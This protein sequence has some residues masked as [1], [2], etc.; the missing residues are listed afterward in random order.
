MR[1]DSSGNVLVG[2]TSA[3]PTSSGVNTPGQELSATGGV[4]STVDSNPAATFNRKTDD[5]SIVLFRKNGTTVGSI[6]IES[7]GFYVDG[8]AGHTG[9]KFRGFDIIPRDNGSDVDAGVNLGGTASRFAALYLS[10]GVYLGGTGAANYLD[11]YEEGTWIPTI[12][13]ASTTPSL[14]VSNSGTYTKVG[15]LV[16]IWG[17]IEITAVASQGTNVWIITS[18]PFTMD[19]QASYVGSAQGNLGATANVT[20]V[21]DARVAD[22]LYCQDED[23][24][25]TNQNF[26]VGNL[27]FTLT[28]ETT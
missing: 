14:T 11:D 21:F 1:I 6:G 28:Y 17:K 18:L 22:Y 15:N 19:T 2:T 25:T 26:Q 13:R 9:L 27:Y 23:G 7:T 20:G 10:G 12:T 5:G 8:E 4:R 3:N 24:G 16:T